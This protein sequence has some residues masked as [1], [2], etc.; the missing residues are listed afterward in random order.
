VDMLAKVSSGS[1]LGVEAYPVTVEVDMASG[2]NRPHIIVGLPD[3]AVK[4][5]KERIE[6]AVLNSGFSFPSFQRFIINL[7]PA[8]TKKEGPIFDLPIAVGVLISSGHVSQQSVE[9]TLLVGELSLDGK[10]R[11]VKGVLSMAIMSHKLGI[12]RM[13][14]PYENAEEAAL[15]GDV[16]VIA[17]ENFMGVMSYLRDPSGS[18]KYVPNPKELSIDLQQGDF[19][20]VKGQQFA[21]RA[22]E[23]AAA[24]GHNILMIGSPGSGKTMLARR[25]PTIMP[26]LS[27][28]EALEVTTLYSVA[29]L[30]PHQQGLINERPFR[31]PHHTISDAGIVG[32]GSIPKPGEI[33]LAHRGILFLDELLEFR[34]T[35]LEM[36][37]Q[38]LEDGEITISRANARLTYPAEF[39]LVGTT[40][41]CPCGHYMD[42]EKKCVCTPQKIKHYWERLSG[43]IL[44][45]I[46]M[47]VEVPR[48]KKEELLKK[49]E[50]EPSAVIRERV[51]KARALQAERFAGTPA[52]SN[53]GMM[54]AQIQ[55]HCQLENNARELL[56][57]GIEQFQLTGRSY[58]RVLRISR[59]IADLE[60]SEPITAKHIAEALQYRTLIYKS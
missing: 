35:C 50:G 36:L 48:L 12:K 16:E 24:G 19:S 29:G 13:L 25:L 28:E 11:P 46:D 34:K 58:D 45:R 43:P 60:G 32:G 57:S 42:T 49:P 18:S 20:E 52:L 14:V 27:R 51:Q 4:E 15:L 8:H 5:S 56:R 38:P 9:N 30:L 47:Y 59:T 21:K 54:P 17:A 26:P 44:D 3:T 10:L 2:I 31:S 39:M 23:I 22:L 1:V 40:N 37:R 6:F 33:T 41:P 7:A 55:A 53:A